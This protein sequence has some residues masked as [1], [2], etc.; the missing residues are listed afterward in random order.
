MSRISSF[1]GIATLVLALGCKKS[2]ELETEYL[3]IF[4]SNVEVNVTETKIGL[5]AFFT[6]QN[7][8]SNENIGFEWSEKYG[9]NTKMFTAGATN[10]GE[11]SLQIDT[12]LRQA[13]TYKVRA[14]V[15][16]GEKIFYSGY[17]QFT[18]LGYPDPEITSLS[19]SYA[20]WGETF[21]I[22]GRYFTENSNNNGISVKIDNIQCQVVFANENKIGIVMPDIETGGKVKIALSVLGKKTQE[23]EVENYR[24]EV[25]SVSPQAMTLN[26]E[27]TIKGKFHSEYKNL[28]IPIQKASDY[29][30][31]EYTVLKYADDEIILKRGT[32]MYCDSLYRIYLRLKQFDY[33][34]FKYLNTGFSIKRTGNWLRLK[35]TPFTSFDK[36][37]S[38]NGKGYVIQFQAN[39]NEFPF[40]RYDPQTDAW[41]KLTSFPGNYRIDPVF[42]ECNGIIY[43]GLGKKNNTFYELMTDLWK[44]D[45]VA[46]TWS[47]CADLNFKSNYGVS[48]FGANIQNAVY[49]FSEWNNQKAKFNPVSNSW[50]ISNCNVPRLHDF[51]SNF[52]FNGEYYFF[53]DLY[54][55]YM[56][57]YNLAISQF[58]Q[59]YLN[60]MDRSGGNAFNVKGRIFSEFAC[61]LSE[62]DILNKNVIELYEY[63]DNV[64]P[65][66]PRRE[67][68]VINDKPYFFFQP[69]G[70][71]TV[72]IE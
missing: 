26:G 14:W 36:G 28:I 49:V 39:S 70:M 43:C 66:I 12:A 53:S 11:F 22:Y 44:Y 55:N 58:D 6:Q 32:Y 71:S 37:L 60:N 17:T 38:S 1:I 45:P 68:F 24:P 47:K 23:T 67:L 3:P 35:N 52:I 30:Y 61:Y 27:I 46:N 65:E 31:P 62:I 2:P 48:I 63:S 15:K 56:Y 33:D 18:G 29:D 9:T 19:K 64:S 41:T 51:S 42:V 54:L 13:N 7:T 8:S 59:I 10:S 50:T 69:S 5:K 4:S 25:F 16:V 21:Y 72:M 40:W 20:Y 34:M 57:K